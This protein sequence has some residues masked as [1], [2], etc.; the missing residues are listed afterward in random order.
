MVEWIENKENFYWIHQL[1]ALKIACFWEQFG[2]S[3]NSPSFLRLCYSLTSIYDKPFLCILNTS[4][5]FS[6]MILFFFWS[7][8]SLASI[9]SRELSNKSLLFCWAIFDSGLG[10]WQN[11]IWPESC[12]V[13]VGLRVV[14]LISVPVCSLGS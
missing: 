8:E 2:K 9:N 11:V 13:F 5:F 12:H 4:T 6:W 1:A 7:L 3:W 14:F 10:C